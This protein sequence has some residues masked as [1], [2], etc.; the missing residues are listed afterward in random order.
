MTVAQENRDL[1]YKQLG[2]PTFG[3]KK[4]KYYTLMENQFM[5]KIY[6]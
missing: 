5:N 1:A 4:I 6:F 2:N 3:G